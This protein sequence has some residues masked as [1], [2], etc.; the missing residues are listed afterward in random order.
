MAR[1]LR[2]I[3][4]AKSEARALTLG[5]FFLLIGSGMMLLYPQAIRV[6]MDRALS[7]GNTGDVD[8]AALAMVAIFTLQGIAS[9]LRYYL[10]TTAGERIVTRLRADLYRRIVLQEISFFDARPTGE[11]MSRL[12]ADAGV[13][14]NAVSV[15]VSMG[16]RHGAMAIGG[17]VL[18]FWISPVLTGLMLAVVP[19]VAISA[20]IYGRRVRV[21]SKRA[22]DALA[23]AA[24]VAEETIGGIRTV[25]SF[26]QEE[27]EALRYKAA[28]EESYEVTRKRI[29]NVSY[30][31]GG[32]S[33]AGYGA[34]ALV[35]WYGG[36]LVV[37]GALSPGELTSF[38][39]YTLTVAFSIGAIGD[40]F[41]DFM[42][43]SGAADRVFELMDRA[44]TIP[45]TGGIKPTSTEGRLALEGVEFR[46][47]TRPDAVVLQD[48]SLSLS[49]GKS[50]ALVGPSGGGKSTVAALV[51]RLYD[52]TQGRVTL[53]GID[54]RELD[55]TWLRQ[56]IGVV[57][58]EPTLLSTS[59]LENIRY[60]K[61]GAT[62]EEVTEAARAANAL[63][64]VERF[65]E[66]FQTQVG[67]RGVQLSGGQ[68]QRVAIARALLKNPAI[69]ILDEAT[70]ALD[71]ESEH[72]VKVALERLQKGRTTLIIAHR[73][74]TVKS[75][76]Q[77]AVISKGRI[78][79]L[80]GHESLMRET[81]GI[82]HKL[83]ERQ[84]VSA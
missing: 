77:V 53:D 50:L 73:L 5:T 29:L 30:F 81:E 46:Y 38:I 32:A 7:G 61:P 57:S 58:Q 78:V 59:I 47:P 34:V 84:F 62:D 54:L 71:A 70:S 22:Q 4:M 40:L 18:L 76:D 2:L 35:L 15:N 3:S 75:A 65:P 6:I 31:T 13:L 36:R 49:K 9:S 17:V 24:E 41:S 44:P 19:P 83:V 55:A 74:S 68:K 66:R 12:S 23:K 67:E 28:V 1:F 8:R 72:L 69:L 14:Q 60:G 37:S 56:Q 25:R 21:L 33:I 26:T 16:L 63:D 45:L 80:G 43:A 11:L 10:F 82:Y 79:Q 51:S 27:A 42:R 64:F 48:F 20:V 52:P 39:L